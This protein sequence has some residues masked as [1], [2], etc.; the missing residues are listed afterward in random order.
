MTLAAAC[1]RSLTDG[2]G[3]HRRLQAVAVGSR[4]LGPINLDRQLV[5]RSREEAVEGQSVRPCAVVDESEFQLVLA[6]RKRHGPLQ[7]EVLQIHHVLVHA[8][9][10]G[11][12]SLG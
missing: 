8:T 10:R 6:E 7:L 11:P 1:S 12:W 5:E 2:F 4:Q 9:Q 3:T